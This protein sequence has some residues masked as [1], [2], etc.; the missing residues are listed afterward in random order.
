VSLLVSSIALAPERN[1]PS[2]EGELLDGSSGYEDC[3]RKIE[4]LVAD[5]VAFQPLARAI[6]DAHLLA[7]DQKAALWLLAW[8]LIGPDSD[9]AKA[10]GT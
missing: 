7:A 9:R 5:D 3:R 8:S 1:S 10:R 2:P 6:D 4:E